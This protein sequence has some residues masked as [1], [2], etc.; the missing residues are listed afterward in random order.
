M[1]EEK[2]MVVGEYGAEYPDESPGDGAIEQVT[3]DDVLDLL[4]P[5]RRDKTQKLVMAFRKRILDA[6]REVAEMQEREAALQNANQAHVAHQAK[7]KAEREELFALLD[8]NAPGWRELREENAR[9]KVKVA[10]VERTRQPLVE[11]AATP[12]WWARLWG[13]A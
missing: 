12:S 7:L 3:H 4:G 10:E 11:T 9:L 13:R 5:S 1:S 2:Q 8:G 6:E